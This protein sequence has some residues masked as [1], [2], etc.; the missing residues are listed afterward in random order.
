M[1]HTINEVACKTNNTIRGC[2]IEN[3]RVGGSSAPL[4]TVLSISLPL[5]ACR[6]ASDWVGAV[7]SS[8]PISCETFATGPVMVGRLV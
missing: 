1:H 7:G 6:A 5:L 8:T 2:R 4:R 3:P